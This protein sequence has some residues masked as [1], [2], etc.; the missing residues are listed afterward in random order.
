VA[1]VGTLF[2][3]VASTAVVQ[4]VMEKVKAITAKKEQP[5]KCDYCGNQK[6]LDNFW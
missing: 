3:A 4:K 1:G 6:Y 2:L 5:Q